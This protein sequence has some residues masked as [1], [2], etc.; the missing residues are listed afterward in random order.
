MNIAFDRHD[1]EEYYKYKQCVYDIN[2]ILDYKLGD[3]DD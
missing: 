2:W 3:I 1:I